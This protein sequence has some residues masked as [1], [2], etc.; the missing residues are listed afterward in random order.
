MSNVPLYKDTQNLTR[1]IRI[2]GEDREKDIDTKKRITDVIL[3]A[4]SLYF[5]GFG[6]HEENLSLLNLPDSAKNT[7]CIFVNNYDGNLKINRKVQKLFN[8]QFTYIRPNGN[9][10]SLR[11][12]TIIEKKDIYQMLSED[13]SLTEPLPYS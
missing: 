6:F 10:V 7:P 1:N 13:I 8:N 11:T 5:L 2:I 3:E 4:Q 12:P 9:I